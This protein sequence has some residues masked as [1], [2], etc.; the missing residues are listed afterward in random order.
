MTKVAALCL[1]VVYQKHK[2]KDPHAEFY[3]GNKALA[4]RLTAL[5]YAQLPT[6]CL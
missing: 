4:E 2:N 3:K 1:A 6:T 5:N